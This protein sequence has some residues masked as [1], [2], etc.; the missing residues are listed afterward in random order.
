MGYEFSRLPRRFP[1]GTRYV[2]EGRNGLIH[3]RY[4]EFPDGR[5]I[6]LPADLAQRAR[7]PAPA[8]VQKP[9]TKKKL[10]TAGTTP[11]LAS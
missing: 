5:T 6:A 8:P 3:L 11:R 1:T 2:I 4:L 7:R 9:A 10:A